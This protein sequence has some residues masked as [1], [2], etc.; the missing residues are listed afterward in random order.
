MRIQATRPAFRAIPNPTANAPTTADTAPPQKMVSVGAGRPRSVAHSW[1][2]CRVL[3][4]GSGSPICYD[5]MSLSA[6]PPC[7]AD[8]DADGVVGVTELLL[9]SVPRLQ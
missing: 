6:A 8:R 7:P 3:G 2:C 9:L 5:D 4:N 1:W